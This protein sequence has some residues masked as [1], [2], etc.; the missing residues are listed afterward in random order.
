MGPDRPS[1]LKNIN[2]APGGAP[3]SQ[4]GEQ[5]LGYILGALEKLFLGARGKESKSEPPP[6]VR[7]RGASSLEARAGPDFPLKPIP[8]LGQG[9]G[10]G[11]RDI[12]GACF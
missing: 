12:S 5:R 4:R 11:E 10:Q 7:Q 9:Q 2:V 1:G 8:V 6:S 3:L